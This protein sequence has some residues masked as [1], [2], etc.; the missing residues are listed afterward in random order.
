MRNKKS[1][2]LTHRPDFLA[3]TE[4]AKFNE[5]RQTLPPSSI[6]DHDRFTYDLGHTPIGTAV[7]V[8]DPVSGQT[9]D[10]TDYSLW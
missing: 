2:L 4:I 9:C 7:K 6:D 8:I 3:D 10:I 5:W 1:F